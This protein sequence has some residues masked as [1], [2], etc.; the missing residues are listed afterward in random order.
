MMNLLLS[1]DHRASTSK[2][3]NRDDGGASSTA[4][5]KWESTTGTPYVSTPAILSPFSLGVTS[6]ASGTG[7]R[8]AE[9][10]ICVLERHSD[11]LRSGS[12]LEGSVN[13]DNPRT[14]ADHST[15]QIKSDTRVIVFGRLR[16]P[17][18][19]FLHFSTWSQGGVGMTYHTELGACPESL[20]HQCSGRMRLKT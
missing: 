17:T 14:L 2:R 6:A 16:V 18:L 20:R 12:Y 8:R 19:S 10:S 11:A 9:I 15:E 5:T 4:G 3:G 1:I 13:Y 7:G